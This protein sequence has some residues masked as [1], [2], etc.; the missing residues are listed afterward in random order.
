MKRYFTFIIILAVVL[1]SVAS[2]GASDVQYELEE[3][4]EVAAKGDGVTNIVSGHG[5]EYGI[6]TPEIP[7]GKTLYSLNII[8]CPTWTNKNGD[9]NVDIDVYKWLGDFDV[10]MDAKSLYHEEVKDHQDCDDLLITFGPTALRYGYRYLI[11]FHAYDG[12]VGYWHASGHP[13]G[14]EFYGNLGSKINVTPWISV[15]YANV[16][17][18]GPEPTDEPE[19]PITPLPAGTPLPADSTEPVSLQT[20]DPAQTD[21]QADIQTEEQADSADLLPL[22]LFCLSGTIIFVGAMLLII[23]KKKPSDK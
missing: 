7:A 1:T 2:A 20:A 4:Q 17:D 22:S 16:G 12:A 6:L 5:G 14:W 11:V 9:S 23:N 15:T 13:D 19:P 21:E 8:G 3:A 10:S 18:L